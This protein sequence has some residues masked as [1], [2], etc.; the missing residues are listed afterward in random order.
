MATRDLYEA[1]EARTVANRRAFLPQTLAFSG[2]TLVVGHFVEN[3]PLPKR[4]F[5]LAICLRSDTIPLNRCRKRRFRSRCV[6][7][8]R[9]APSAD[10]GRPTRQAPA[11][12]SETL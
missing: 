9:R 3:D 1:G 11:R 6:L 5:G 10:A 12:T 2:Q 7:N 4:S 8:P